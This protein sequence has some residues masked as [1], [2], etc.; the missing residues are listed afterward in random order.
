MVFTSPLSPNQGLAC[1]S[2]F[3]PDFLSRENQWR[4]IRRNRAAEMPSALAIA[5]P[6]SL[7]KENP[8][9]AHE[10]APSQSEAWSSFDLLGWI[11]SQPVDME[12]GSWSADK[13]RSTATF[14]GR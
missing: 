6:Y 4:S 13:A 5:I 1:F 12:T 8:R 3:L 14:R 2:A 10:Q 7:S 9:L 11:V